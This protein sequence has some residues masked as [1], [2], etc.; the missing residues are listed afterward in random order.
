[1]RIIYKY[2]L[3]VMG[4]QEIEMP[5][6]A[7]V[8]T[9]QAQRNDPFIWVDVAPN[10]P[11]VK[12]RFRTYGTGQPMKDWHEFPHYVGTYQLNDGALVFHVYTDRV[13]RA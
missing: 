1:M 9:V 3:P 13:E 10:A 12:R 11:K 2:A 6:G 5:K 8:L 4:V 7:A